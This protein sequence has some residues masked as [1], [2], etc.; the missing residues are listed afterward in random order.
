[1]DKP[2][3]SGIGLMVTAAGGVLVIAGIKDVPVLTVL[4]AFAG[5]YAPTGA[6]PRTTTVSFTGVADGAPAAGG[7]D[8]PA[9]GSAPAAGGTGQAIAEA[10]R[11]YIGIPYSWGGKNPAKGLDCS[12]LVHQAILDATGVSCPLSSYTQSTWSGFTAVKR[13]EV[14]AG[15]VC[16]WFGH[17][18]V[19]VSNTR[20]ISA[21]RPGLSVREETI[22]SAGPAGTGSPTRC[23]RFNGRGT[24]AAAGQ[25]AA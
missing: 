13:S 10:A 12:G 24:K 8:A 2:G 22:N 16:W 4:R 21:P 11:K 20:C 6:G 19:A 17:V 25:K 3:V 9:S 18:V 1:M 7:T 23:L 15:D 5:G 14:A